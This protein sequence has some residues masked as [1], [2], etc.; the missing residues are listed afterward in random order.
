MEIRLCDFGCAKPLQSGEWNKSYIC[1]RY[2]RA[3]ELLADEH[4][5]T[6][7]I[8]TWSVGCIIVEL[9]TLTPLFRGKNTA[10]QLK[11]IAAKLGPMPQGYPSLSDADIECYAP[12]F[13]LLHYFFF[14]SNFFLFRCVFSGVI[15]YKQFLSTKI[16]VFFLIFFLFRC[17]CT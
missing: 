15:F 16:F 12:G 1:S 5:Y 3:P 14:Y 10:Q 2:Y 7:N 13:I 11:Y 8:D 4:Y 17:K 9:F 6:T